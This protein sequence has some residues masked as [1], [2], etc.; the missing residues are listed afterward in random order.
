MPAVVTLDAAS[1]A[2]GVSLELSEEMKE[3]MRVLGYVP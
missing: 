2:P 1:P 3:R